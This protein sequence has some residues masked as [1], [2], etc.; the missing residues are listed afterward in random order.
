MIPVSYTHLVLLALLDTLFLVCTCYRMLETSWVCRV[1]C[2]RNTNVL[3]MHDCNTFLNVICTVA[4]YSSA[5]SVG[6][7]LLVYNV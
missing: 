3:V 6:V 1:S 4:L 7:C 2:D 5:K